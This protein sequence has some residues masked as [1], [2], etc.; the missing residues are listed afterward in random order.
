V[1]TSAGYHA[2]GVGPAEEQSA[3]REI[4]SERDIM[5]LKPRSGGAELSRRPLYRTRRRS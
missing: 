4:A 2:G 5:K 3:K 1:E